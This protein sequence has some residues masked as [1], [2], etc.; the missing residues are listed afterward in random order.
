VTGGKNSSTEQ[1]RSVALA[2][3]IAQNNSMVDALILHRHVDHSL[4][5]ATGA[6]FGLYTSSGGENASEKKPSWD[7]YRLA[8]TTKTNKYTRYAEKQAK[9][10]TGKTIKKV[11]KVQTGKL[12]TTTG[13][14]WKKYCTAGAAG[15]GAL[16]GFSWVNNTYLLTHDNARNA[17]VVWGIRRKGKVNCSSRKKLGFGIRVNGALNGKCRVTVR[18]WAGKKRFYEAKKVIPC[19][20]SVGLYVNLKKWKY[21]KK[22]SRIDILISPAGSRWAKDANAA[23]YAI[24]TGK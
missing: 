16:S 18:L 3:Y 20:T 22:I 21:R 17:N 23:I 14:K 15:Y 5:A 6:A 7:A 19:K 8:D 4:E 13:L 12:K 11:F 1:A 9:K 2:Y 24:G 10:V